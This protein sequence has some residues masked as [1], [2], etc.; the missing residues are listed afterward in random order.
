M[1]NPTLTALQLKLRGRNMVPLYMA[2]HMAL[3]P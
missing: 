3:H 2:T 1:D